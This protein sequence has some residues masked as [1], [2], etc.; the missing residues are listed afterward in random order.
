MSGSTLRLLISFVFF[1]HGIGQIMGIIPVFRLFG[2]DTGSPPGWAKNWSSRS[3]LLTDKLGES[4]SCAVCFLLYFVAFVLFIASALALQGWVFSHALW[5]T[6]AV[7][8]A[9]VSLFALFLFWK[10]LIYFFPHKV[11]D[12]GVN[13]AVLLGLLVF[14]LP[15]ENLLG[16]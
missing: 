14:R 11:G 16:F 5:Q 12:I 13:V 8:G 6:L 10:A 3:W 4:V 9:L 7:A 2:S 15:S 1:V